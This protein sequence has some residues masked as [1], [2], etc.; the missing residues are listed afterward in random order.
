MS[1]PFA[2]TLEEV[3]A[4]RSENSALRKLLLEVRECWPG[5]A[6]K[7]CDCNTC[8]VYW[9]MADALPTADVGNA[10]SGS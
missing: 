2:T 4:L 5:G 8:A 3:L 9:R 10:G 7:D 1:G 6:E